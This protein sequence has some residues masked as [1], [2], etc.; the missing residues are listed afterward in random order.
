MLWSFDLLYGSGTAG[1]VSLGK[2]VQNKKKF[3]FSASC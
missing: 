3:L 2:L 1:R